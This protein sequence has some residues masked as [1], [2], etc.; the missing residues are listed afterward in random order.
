[1]TSHSSRYHAVNNSNSYTVE[2]RVFRGTLNAETFVATVDFAY[3]LVKNAKD[4]VDFKNVS[5]WLKGMRPETIEYIKSRG[6]FE[7]AF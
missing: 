1:M 5:E 7:G 4:V 2:L 6:A 3:N